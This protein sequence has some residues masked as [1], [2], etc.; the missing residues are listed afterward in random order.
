MPHW[1]IKAKGKKDG[2]EMTYD[3]SDTSIDPKAVQAQFERTHGK[4]S[5]FVSAEIVGAKPAAAEAKPQ[6]K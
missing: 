1:I 3:V 6:Q 2:K 5:E 4:D